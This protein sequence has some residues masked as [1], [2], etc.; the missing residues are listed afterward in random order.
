[1]LKKIIC[2]VFLL[3]MGFEAVRAEDVKVKLNSAD[4][5]TSFQVRNSADVVVSSITSDGDANFATVNTTH[6][7]TIGSD[8]RIKGN[9]VFFGDSQTDRRIYDD[10]ANYSTRFSSNVYIEQGAL[11]D[12]TVESD[13]LVI[14]S[15]CGYTND[16][17]GAPTWNVYNSRDI[18]VTA[19][20]A[21]IIVMVT[22]VANTWDNTTS[23]FRI[24]IG[25]T[26]VAANQLKPDDER[27]A[28]ESAGDL[29]VAVVGSLRV[30]GTGTYAC[31][32]EGT[33]NADQVGNRSMVAFW[34]GSP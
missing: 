13:D 16:W 23:K 4:G 28:S 18:D 30:T 1:M 15:S 6:S 20:P 9:D 17:A 7:V 5:S 25:G 32:F 34:V 3:F 19:Q 21:L 12:R 8:V 22:A 2:F 14:V 10:S 29:A 24:T 26:Q 33:N 31:N 27:T 11:R